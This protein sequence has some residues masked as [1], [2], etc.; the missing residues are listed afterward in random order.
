[1]NKLYCFFTGLFILSVFNVTKGQQ[2]SQEI[3]DLGLKVVYVTTVDGEEPTAEPITAPAGSWGI[4]LTNVTKVPGSVKIF[5]PEGDLLYDSGEYLKKESGMTIKIRGNTSALYDKKPFKIKLEKKADLLLRDDK[6]LRDKNWLLLA[7][8]DLLRMCGFILGK[9]AGMEWAPAYEWV[10]VVVNGDYRGNYMLVEAVERNETC[11]IRTE[12]TGFVTERDA[13]WWNENGE[14]LNS[15]WL[16][17]FGWTMKYPDFEDFTEEQK[18]Y[19]Q[20][21]IDEYEA[22]LS[23]EN[24]TDLIDIDSFCRWVICQDVLGT[25]DGGGTNLFIAKKDNTPDSKLYVPVLWDTDSAEE[26]EN[27]WSR[28]H[29]QTVISLL[30]NNNNKAFVHHFIN[31]YNE[32]SADLFQA[33][34]DLADKCLTEEYDAYA[35][36]AEMNN[37]R[38]TRDNYDRALPPQENADHLNWWLNLRKPW[39][40]SAVAELAKTTAVDGVAYESDSILDLFVNNGV[41]VVRNAGEKINVYSVDGR[42]VYSGEPKDIPL[43]GNGVYIITSGIRSKKI[44]Y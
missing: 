16:P 44:V 3:L 15:L 4:G 19:V 43:P 28:V 18:N 6:N 32:I 14:Y 24:Y 17:Q 40:D 38:W 37:K 34:Q 31:L 25:S 5:S 23:T 27:E 7:D 35:R 20:S 26:V 29:K 10:N 41:L 2:V 13:Y 42:S 39:L 33:L 1:M 8:R 12:E 36:S 30:F 11:R 22:I 9:V 21:V